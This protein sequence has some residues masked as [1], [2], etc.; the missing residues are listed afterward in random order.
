MR[1]AGISESSLAKT[2]FLEVNIHHARANLSELI[3]AVES[4]EDVI[5][6]RNSKP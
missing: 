6:A 4:G 3:V 5:I 2:A 1:P